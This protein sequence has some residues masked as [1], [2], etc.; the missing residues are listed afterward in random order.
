MNECLDFIHK[1]CYIAVIDSQPLSNDL[2]VSLYKDKPESFIYQSGFDRATMQHHVIIKNIKA[3]N[4]D[5]NSNEPVSMFLGGMLD[6][7]EEK[8]GAKV[9]DSFLNL[10]HG[11]VEKTEQVY[12]DDDDDNNPDAVKLIQS[13]G[14][15]KLVWRS[16]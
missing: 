14:E 12:D 3:D 1:N 9:G 8:L 16:A 10:N 5:A 11:Q 7:I 2:A 15:F 6:L 13:K 4:D